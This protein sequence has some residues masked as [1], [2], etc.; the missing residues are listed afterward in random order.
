MF[1][2]SGIFLK[3]QPFRRQPENSMDKKIEKISKKLSESFIKNE[4]N[5]YANV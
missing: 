5:H 4:V 3:M 1:Q 2:P